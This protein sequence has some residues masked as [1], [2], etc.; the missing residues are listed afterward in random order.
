MAP[1]TGLSAQLMTGEETTYGTPVTPDRAYEFRD[2]KLQMDIGRIESKALRAGT[3]IVRSDR[4]APGK[5][6][7]GGEITMELANKSFGR[8]FKHSFGTVASSQPDG[9]GN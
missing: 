8:W 5:R 6:S 7:V 9:A 3:R 2:E 1:P 4:W